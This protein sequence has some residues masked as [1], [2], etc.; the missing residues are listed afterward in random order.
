[1]SA[2]SSGN[3]GGGTPELAVIF[4]LEDPR[5]DVVDHLRT[6][7]DYQTLSRERYQIVVGTN[8]E[9]PDFERQ[10]AEELEP[11]DRMVTARDV[12]EPA[13]AMV[14]SLYDAAARV[15]DAPVLVLTEAH[16]RADPGVLKA[17]ADAFAANDELDA[18]SF[19]HRQEAPGSLAELSERWFAR[20]HAAWKS[21]DWTRINPG[22]AAVTAHAYE[23]AGGL[24]HEKELFS[25]SFM[26]ARFHHQGGRLEHLPDAGMVHVLEDT[27]GES[28]QHGRS[29][30]RGECVAR[31]EYGAEFCDRYFGPGGLWD[32]RYAYRPDVARAMIAALG[33][34][35]REAPRE[36]GWLGR[37]LLARM[38]ARVAGSLPRRAWERGVAAVQTLVA[39][40][41]VVPTETRWRSYIDAT[42]RTVSA[43]RLRYG[44]RA[45]GLPDPLAPGEALPPERFEGVAIGMH[46]LESSG[47][48]PFRWTEPVALLR[49]DGPAAGATLRI[50][51]GGLRGAPLDY[52]QGIYSGGEA[53]PAELLSDDDGTLEAR[54]PAHFAAADPGIVLLSRPLVVSGDRRRLGMPVVELELSSP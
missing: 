38:P 4:P 17:V 24:E 32:R 23:R 11:Q 29:F 54:L 2:K 47:S 36:A 30:A 53:L 5:G 16:C 51:T 49:L 45:N 42:E 10:I 9:H 20:A 13:G 27:M 19:E 8:G 22:G 21:R 41:S 50:S 37:E 7:T 48:L 12:T 26:S 44:D 33:S 35:I 40:S 46:S 3:G 14:I 39:D 15:A 6:W 28:L 25:P 43:I 52:V 31:G 18:A 1:M 34:A